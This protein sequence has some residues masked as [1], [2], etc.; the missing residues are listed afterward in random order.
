MNG[1]I[2]EVRDPKVPCAGP[3]SQAVHAG[4]F[5]FVSGQLPIDPE[6]G[7]IV[8]EDIKVQTET[9]I[10]YVERILAVSGLGLANVVKS[11]VFVKDINDFSAV[12]EVYALKFTGAVKPARFVIESAKLPKNVKIELACTAYAGR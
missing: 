1:N 9:V 8:S 11:E 10:G 2:K 12:N 4:D 7:A 6:T 5:I 3:Y